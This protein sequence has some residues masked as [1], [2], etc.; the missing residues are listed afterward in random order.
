MK[1]LVSFVSVF[2]AVL[3]LS[4]AQ[5]AYAED[6]KRN[7]QDETIYFIMID[8]F[9]NGD[10]TNDFDVNTQDPYAYHGG[11]FQ[12]I[13]DKLD[14]IEQ[15]GFTAIWLT[16]IFDNS[17]KGYHGYWIVDFYNTEEHFGT[18]EEFKQL[19]EEAHRRDIKVIIDFVV[20]H[21][22]PEHP[23]LDEPEKADW[24][25]E[26]KEIMNWDDP[27]QLETGWIYDLPDLAQEN[28]EVADY[29]I[30]AAKWW[31]RETNIDGFRLDTVKHVPLHFW[32]RFAREVKAVKENF[33]LLGEVW[34]EHPLHIAPY[35][36]AGL[37][38]ATDYPLY[39]TLV[40]TFSE[41]NHSLK[42]AFQALE[43]N[44]AI[45]EHPE[46]MGKFI[47]NHD[48]PRFT[49]FV[50]S[51]NYHPEPRW[52]QALTFMYTTPGI[53]IIY[54]GSEI[55]LNGGSDPDNRRMMEFHTNV[56]LVEFISKLG[57]IRK[58]YPSLT[59]GELDVLYEDGG[60]AIYKR[61]YKDETT[62]I[63]LNNT[64]EKQIVPLRE[65]DIGTGMELA[66]VLN[67]DLVKVNQGQYTFVINPEE[68]EIYLVKPA[69]G[70]NYFT[71]FVSIGIF[72]VFIMFI[73][74]ARKRGERMNQQ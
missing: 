43:R 11:D 67:G 66:G 74:F 2:L 47:D 26:R 21:T 41:P 53:P 25:H 44:A 60:M 37:D 62:I 14:Y 12:G 48:N 65:E 19:V 13:I 7:W 58:T 73:Y 72:V 55:A 54:Y 45:Y 36:E 39:Q 46:L 35:L 34:V 23:W 40:D 4:L 56:E 8:R 63:A 38:G 24:F 70:L 64:T 5:P 50:T 18:I 30:E 59:R 6:G 42:A 20:N 61:T 3:L 28:P 49:Y 22:S 33:Y 10:P 27:E 32:E 9:A 1:K 71:L 69:T 31:I 16:P 51:K 68:S 57:S 52:K 29:L 17:E 15:L